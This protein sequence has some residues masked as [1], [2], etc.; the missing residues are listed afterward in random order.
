MICCSVL[1]LEGLE[2]GLSFVLIC[3]KVLVSFSFFFY[4]FSCVDL[5]ILASIKGEI[6]LLGL[7]TYTLARDFVMSMVSF[8]TY[9]RQ[10]GILLLGLLTYTLSRDFVMPV[11]SFV[12]Y[13]RQGGILLL[14]LLTYTLSRDFIMSVASFVT[15]IHQGG[16]LLL[17]HFVAYNHLGDRQ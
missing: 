3:C 7:L 11:T 2:H 13:I 15:Y 17:S 16:I 9:N 1:P 4:I 10:G 8:V 12:T 14:S 5:S 6:L